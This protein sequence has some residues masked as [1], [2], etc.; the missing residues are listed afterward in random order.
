MCSWEHLD[1]NVALPLTTLMLENE[2]YSG[3]KYGSADFPTIKLLIGGV[4]TKARMTVDFS[5]DQVVALDL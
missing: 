4:S 3:S 2:N 1:F 5:L